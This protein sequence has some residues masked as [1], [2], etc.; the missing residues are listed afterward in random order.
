ML[1]PE[2]PS[3]TRAT[4]SEESGTVRISIPM[5]RD[6]GELIFLAVW[7]GFWIF[8]ARSSF[9]AAGKDFGPAWLGL[10]ILAV[11]WVLHTV[12]RK[13]AGRD[14]MTADTKMIGVRQEILGIGITQQYEV[15]EIRYL[16]FEPARG[17][18][19]PT[20]PAISRSTAASKPQASAP[21]SVE[22]KP[23][24]LFRC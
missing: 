2:T 17:R 24:R 15:A 1:M 8:L 3:P 9:H 7:L 13:L 11:A 18:G 10:W 14:V 6:W 23:P 21:V 5:R 16:H 22:K 12:L 4:I 20:G 19:N